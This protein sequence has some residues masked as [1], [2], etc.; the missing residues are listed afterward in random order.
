MF[1]SQN[2][3]LKRG[4]MQK[5]TPKS[6]TALEKVPYFLKMP[7]FDML[8]V[9][10]ESPS[11]PQNNPYSTFSWSCMLLT[12]LYL[13][14]PPSHSCYRIMLH[15]KH[16]DLMSNV[17][18]HVRTNTQPLIDIA[19]QRVKQIYDVGRSNCMVAHIV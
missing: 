9:I 17:Q 5:F 12:V 6:D 11:N 18:V 8:N 2:L 13:T 10:L 4:F 1:L 14:A 3:T 19:R 16:L 7:I 15:I